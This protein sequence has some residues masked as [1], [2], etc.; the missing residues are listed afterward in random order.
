M[1]MRHINGDIKVLLETYCSAI[2]HQA[3]LDIAKLWNTDVKNIVVQPTT[4][5]NCEYCKSECMHTEPCLEIWYYPDKELN[6]L[7]D[8]FRPRKKVKKK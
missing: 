5:S 2:D 7:S 1:S 4:I 8:R 6:W 3:L